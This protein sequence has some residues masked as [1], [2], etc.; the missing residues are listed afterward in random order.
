MYFS[1]PKKRIRNLKILFLIGMILFAFWLT[2]HF[3]NMYPDIQSGLEAMG[4]FFFLIAIAYDFW[5]FIVASF[6]L[7]VRYK[8][9][10]SE[11]SLKKDLKILFGFSILA[12]VIS[13]S[14]FRYGIYRRSQLEFSLKNESQ[15]E[16]SRIVVSLREKE[17]KVFESI[18][19]DEELHAEVYVSGA[20]G[21]IKLKVTFNNEESIEHLLLGYVS[22]PVMKLPKVHV[23]IHENSIEKSIVRPSKERKLLE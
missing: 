5:S 14:A 1:N 3:T 19:I 20:E 7:V 23:I 12:A 17:L 4:L 13:V 11:E 2:L 6:L 21:S 15:R 22:P 16:I 10:K 8:E 9:V 18:Q